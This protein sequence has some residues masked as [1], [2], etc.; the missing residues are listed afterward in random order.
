MEVSLNHYLFQ[1]PHQTYALESYQFI[2]GCTKLPYRATRGWI[3]KHVVKATV[4]LVTSSL[5]L[6]L[7]LELDCLW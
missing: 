6:S 4:L 2:W 5:R 1:K 7:N 3:S